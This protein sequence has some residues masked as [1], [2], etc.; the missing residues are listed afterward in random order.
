MING[1]EY[2]WEDMQIVVQGNNKP[3]EGIVEINYEKKKDHTN[4]Y[5]KGSDPKAAGRGKNEYSANVV[6]LQSEFDAWNNSL[7]PGK[8]VTDIKGFNIDVAYAPEGGKE[9]VD[10]LT[11]CRANGF[12]K[13]MK[14]GDGNMT[15]DIALTVGKTLYNV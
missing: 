3:I 4:I 7:G 13:G 1:F 12:K 5:A 6:L 14:T 15:I 9:S 8:D 10:R 2:A 11:F